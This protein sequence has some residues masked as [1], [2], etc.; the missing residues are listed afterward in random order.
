MTYT[1]KEHEEMHIKLNGLTSEQVKYTNS[2]EVREKNHDPGQ[3]AQMQYANTLVDVSKV[4]ELDTEEAIALRQEHKARYEEIK[5]NAQIIIPSE[6]ATE[7]SDFKGE[8]SGRSASKRDTR[9]HM[10]GSRLRKKRLMAE[11]IEK[12]EGMGSNAIVLTSPIVRMYFKKI[13][14]DYFKDLVVI[15]YNEVE[16]D[17]ELQSVGMITA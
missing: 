6:K 17:V 15:S 9:A 11:E 8:D 3:R 13:T 2:F 7:R 16:S 4:K 10:Y 1:Q 5:G 12:L 14:E